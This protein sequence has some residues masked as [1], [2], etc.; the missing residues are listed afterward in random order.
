MKIVFAALILALSTTASAVSRFHH[1][2]VS[3]AQA[4]ATKSALVI[5]AP[6]PAA[7]EIAYFRDLLARA[8]TAPIEDF[9]RLWFPSDVHVVA[10]S[11]LDR[12]I[13]LNRTEMK[14]EADGTLSQDCKPDVLYSWGPEIKLKTIRQDLQDGTNWNK[15]LNGGRSVWVTISPISTYAYGPIPIRFK[16]KPQAKFIN[17]FVENAV[18]EHTG[19]LMDFLFD[20]ANVLESW[21]FGMPQHYDEIVKDILQFAKTTDVVTYSGYRGNEPDYKNIYI[22][23]VVE[24]RAQ[25]EATLRENLT[26]MIR[27]ILENKGEVHYASGVTHSV[28]KHFATDHPT[29]FNER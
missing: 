5:D 22:A 6:K 16:F 17:D 21:S 15:P 23:G 24:R 25:N 28:Q 9:F 8:E 4:P 7:A 11:Y 3:A 13:D 29:Y 1:P 14:R 2:V 27:M 20:N 12:C 10:D 26:L 18:V 19:G